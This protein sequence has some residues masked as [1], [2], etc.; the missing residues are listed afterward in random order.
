[1]PKIFIAAAR[2]LG[3]PA[4]Y[5]SGYLLRNDIVSQEASHAWA[6]AYVDGLGW[7]GFDVSNGVSPDERY[8]RLA[9]GLDS[10]DAA[11]IR[12]VRMGGTNE[13]MLVSLQIQQ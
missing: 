7:V 11:P 9:I 4:R 12:G 1:M 5:V 13:S 6:E 8:V 10:Y 2:Q 3:I